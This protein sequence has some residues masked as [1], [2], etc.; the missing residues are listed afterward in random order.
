MRN[1]PK[2]A[3][4]SPPASAQPVA[5]VAAAHYVGSAACKDC[6][7][8]IY[9][10]WKKTRMANVVRDPQEHPDAI[11]PDLSK[12]DPL[13]NVH[14]GRHRLRLWQQVEAALLQAG[15]R[16]LF[17]AA[18]AVGRDA[19][20]LARRISCKNGTD[21]WAPLY[22][23]D[24]FQRPTGPL[25]DGCHSVNYDIADQDS[26]RMECRLREV[27][28]P[29]QR[30]CRST[31]ARQHRQSGAARLRAG[32]RHLHSMPFAGP[33]AE[34]SDRRA[35]ITIGRSASTSAG[36]WRISGSWKS[37]S[38]AR[39]SF[40]HFADGTAHKNRMQGND[41]VQSL[42]YTRGVTCFSCHD[43]H[44]T[45]NNAVLWKP[46]KEICL[47]CHGP[48]IAERAA[49]A[50]HRGAYASQGGQHGQ[51]VRRL[52]HAQDRADHR[53]RQRA[54]PHLQV[55]HARRDRCVEDSERVQ[56]LSHGQVDRMGER[57]IE[58][59]GGALALAYGSMS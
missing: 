24:N 14:Q 20:D 30:A 42:M 28:W 25:C 40:T 41:F 3:A 19:Q 8:D 9:E 15:R 46:A 12:P 37:T 52:P 36:I 2:V 56:C 49:R 33:A 22:P 54:Q 53:G 29:G 26:H 6:H 11:I 59:L 21:W 5:S 18:G 13:V 58:D 57:G 27:P 35:N 1:L 51:R 32:Q 39:P 50:D 34:E 17:S 31:R 55:H 47:D 38:W 10:R 44:G 7:T 48:N 16:R 45:A 43:V 23:P 4:L